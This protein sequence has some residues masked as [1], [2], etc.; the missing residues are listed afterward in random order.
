MLG[1]ELWKMILD[2][3]PSKPGLQLVVSH[4]S[5]LA[6]NESLQQQGLAGQ[7]AQVAAT[8]IPVNL[9]A[10][11]RFAKGYS[12]EDAEFSLTGITEMT[13]VNDEIP[14]LHNL[15]N[16]LRTLTFAPGFNQKL[17]HVKLPP[18]LQS[19]NFGEN[20]NQSL[21]SVAWPATLQSLTFGGAFDQSLD[22]VTWP[23]GLQNF[24]LSQNFDQG[25][26]N[27]TWPV[28]L[29]TLTFGSKF[30]QSLDNVTWPAGLQSLTFGVCFNQSLDNVAW[31]ADLQ[32]LIFGVC[33]NQSLDNVT[34]PADLQSLTFGR[35]FNQSLDN[36]TWPAD[37]QSLTCLS[38]SLI[39]ILAES[40]VVL[41]SSLC[42][43]VA[44]NASD[45]QILWN[46]EPDV[47]VWNF[48]ALFPDKESLIFQDMTG[49]VYRL[50]L[51]E[52][53]V[54]W[55]AGGHPGTWTD[56]GAA[57]GNGM[58]YAVNNNHPRYSNGSLGEHAPGTLSAYDMKGNLQ[59]QVTTPRPPN[60]APVIG[61]VAGWPGMTLILPLC[62]QELQGQ[63]EVVMW[64][65]KSRIS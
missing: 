40:D 31:P 16:S 29:E 38:S 51:A 58:V 44:L 46:F 3:V 10:A 15:P 7:Q 24:T 34:W 49:K 30:N 28:G 20:F 9:H 26:H 22:K 43:L 13:G 11:W 39:D 1:R 33:F 5:R 8:Y 56:G 27:V 64:N 57:L 41:P 61:K 21:D 18:A 47:P 14:A 62:N 12:V 50:S 59:W 2:K 37:L 6:L 63:V 48:L 54:L 4:T 52:G 45:G 35:N 36:V 65:S 53:E 23:A 32:S 55:K 25:L 17:H 42:T 60:N 19:L